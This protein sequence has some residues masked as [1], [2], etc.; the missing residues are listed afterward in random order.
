MI[1]EGPTRLSFF[2]YSSP[3]PSLSCHCRGRS[4][5]VAYII[6]RENSPSRLR[7]YMQLAEYI[8]LLLMDDAE[9]QCGRFSSTEIRRRQLAL[10][11]KKVSLLSQHDHK[12]ESVWNSIFAKANDLDENFLKKVGTPKH[13]MAGAAVLD[14]LPTK[15]WIMERLP[16]RQGRTVKTICSIKPIDLLPRPSPPSSPLP[17]R[18]QARSGRDLLLCT[19][20]ED[21]GLKNGQ[22]SLVNASAFQLHSIQT[23]L[24]SIPF[25]FSPHSSPSPSLLFF[26]T[27]FSFPSLPVGPHPSPIFRIQ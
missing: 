7:S 15:P 11:L 8:P 12:I 25:L 18:R 17:S 13:R 26:A 27:L 4:R 23:S 19:L 9:S 6:S 22:F 16:P 10:S 3:Y 20:T 2:T 5:R 24:V 14:T 1:T 21:L